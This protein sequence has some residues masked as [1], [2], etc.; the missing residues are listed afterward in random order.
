MDHMKLDAG[1]VN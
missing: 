1:D